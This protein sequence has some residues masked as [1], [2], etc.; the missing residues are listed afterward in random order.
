MIKK[1][2]IKQLKIVNSDSVLFSKK[3]KLL[4]YTIFFWGVSIG[5]ILCGLVPGFISFQRI[6]YT[7]D[8]NIFLIT[9]LLLIAFFSIN[10]IGFL[11]FSIQDKVFIKA[12]HSLLIVLG[13]LIIFGLLSINAAI[14]TDFKITDAGYEVPFNFVMYI[15]DL[16]VIFPLYGF[17]DYYVLKNVKNE[18]RIK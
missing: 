3:T 10:I 5:C 17:F 12:K 11:I 15:I 1:T 16:F 8:T 9:Y 7:K 18:F 2:H 4:F 6:F 13:Y 14:F